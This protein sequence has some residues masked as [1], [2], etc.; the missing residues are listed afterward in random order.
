[1]AKKFQEELSDVTDLSLT[2][3]FPTFDQTTL[4]S[5]NAALGDMLKLFVPDTVTLDSTNDTAVI[6]D[7]SDGDTLKKVPL[8]SLLSAMSPVTSTFDP[9]NDGVVISDASD[10]DRVKRIDMS[11]F[12]ALIP[13]GFSGNPAAGYYKIGDLELRWGTIVS[14]TDSAQVFS[15]PAA[16]TNVCAVVLT[17]SIKAGATKAFPVVSKNKTNFTIDRDNG[18]SGSETLN[19]IAIGY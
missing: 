14:S 13:L 2:S 8:S 6:A 9:I 1:M 4:D 7:N 18:I 12:L 10:S 3:K 16:F 5:R 11:T 15:F 19:Y 17:N